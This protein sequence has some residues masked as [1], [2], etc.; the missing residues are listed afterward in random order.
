MTTLNESEIHARL[1]AA[2]P[3]T[4]ELD[5]ASRDPFVNLPV[6]AL[7]DALAFLRDDPACSME[8]LHLVTA[9]EREAAMEVAYHVSSL[10]RH[11]TLTL[12]VVL[13]RPEG[14]GHANWHPEVPSVS[15]LYVSADWHEREQFDLLG[16]R[17]TGHPDLRRILLPDEWIGFPLRKDY[18]YPTEHGG[19]PLELDA[20][21]IYERG[22]EWEQ[23]DKIRRAKKTE[24][25]AGAPLPQPASPVSDRPDAGGKAPASS[26]GERHSIGPIKEPGEGDSGGGH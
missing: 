9:T 17:F 4:G 20:V 13:P 22:P 21:P 23:E 15:D 18:S 25:P 8:M 16:V 24:R 6:E 26:K 11:H 3:A 5:T 19:I 7:R 10:S 14:G 2:V 1:K 12:K